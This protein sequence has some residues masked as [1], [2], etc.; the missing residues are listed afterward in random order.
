MD[1]WQFP[2]RAAKLAGTVLACGLAAACSRDHAPPQPAPAPVVVVA[3]ATRDMPVLANAPGN[4][5]A[6]NSV[7][8][9]SL[10]DGQLLESFVKDGADVS[11]GQ[12]LFRIDPR[13]AQA[14]LQQALAQ[15]AKDQATLA[16]AR[17]QVK[18]YEDLAAKGYL[19]ADQME[20]YRTNLEAA[21]ASVKV[22]EA[23]VAAARVALSYTD[24]HAPLAGRI[25]RIL[26]QPGN[27]VKAN[28]TNPLVT[29]NQIEPIYV[30][31]SLPSALLGRVQAAQKAAPLIARAS[32]VGI[33]EPVEG[34]VAFI[35][36]AVDT[37]TGTVRLRA[38]FPNTGHV[39]WPGQLVG[40]SLTIGHDPD[41]IV[42]PARAVQNGP[43]GAYVFVVHSDQTAE[44]RSVGVA[45]VV[46]GEAVIERGL[47]AGETVV[48]DG[49][50]R[51]EDKAAVKVMPASG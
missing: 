20:Q 6:I 46:A 17:S 24:I 11:A 12:L 22:D 30:N 44:Q 3:A 48:V 13:P 28:D 47:A 8:V 42:V 16:Q 4:V 7:A 10:V 37:S 25:G 1:G 33:D 19:S 29:I 26:I 31:F 18:R 14:A 45:R 38:E 50:S 40:V 34:K 36:N 49:Q 5:E 27:V 35:D 32:V 9:K 23:N 15:Q 41:A 51:V 2:Q 21:R 43:D 39:L